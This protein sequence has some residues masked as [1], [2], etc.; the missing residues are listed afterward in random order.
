MIY[1][2]NL[3]SKYRW[4]LTIY[5]LTP[6]FFNLFWIWNKITIFFL[7]SISIVFILKYKFSKFKT[8]TTFVIILIWLINFVLI[9]F[10]LIPTENQNIDIKNF[11]KNKKNYIKILIKD[12]KEKLKEENAILFIPRLWIKKLRNLSNNKKIEVFPKDKIIYTS[13]SKN[14]KTIINLYL[15]D[16]TIIRI[17][18]QTSIDLKKIYKNLN[19]LPKSETKIKVEWWNIRFRVIKTIVDDKW[20]NIE[21]ND[22]TLIIRWTAWFVRKSPTSTL[23]YS[24]DHIIEWENKNWLKFLISKKQWVIIKKDKIKKLN[25]NQIINILWERLY[26]TLI[27]IKQIDQKDINKYKQE[28]VEYLK[29]NFKYNFEKI[30]KLS[31]YKIW[32]LSLFSEKYKKLL[33]NYNIFQILVEWKKSELLNTQKLKDIIFIPI[34]KTINQEKLEYLKKMAT[35][36]TEYLKTLIIQKTN[37]LLDKGKNIDLNELINKIGESKF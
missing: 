8:L 29:Q 27:K 22:W 3:L 1:I 10:A 34:N 6:L 28:F 21:T 5:I 20:F 19:N 26:K 7:I 4:I 24:D 25:Y 36:N 23:A 2:K 35:T 30:N 31:Y 33:E 11:Y 18:P 16:W 32:L 17:F 9:V 37:D 15:W 14:L 13:K 12:S